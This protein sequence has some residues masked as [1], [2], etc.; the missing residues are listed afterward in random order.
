MGRGNDTVTLGAGGA[1]FISLNRD[2]DRIKFNP[3]NYADQHV[4]A[5]GGEGVTETTDKDPIL[6]IS[7]P[8]RPR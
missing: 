2:A 1:D 6:L 7:P 4:I 3:L 8:L 5:D